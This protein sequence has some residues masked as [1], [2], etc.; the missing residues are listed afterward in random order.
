MCEGKLAS[1]GT[2]EER[3]NGSILVR[4]FTSLVT[5]ESTNQLIVLKISSPIHREWILLMVLIPG[6]IKSDC[7]IPPPNTSNSL[8][9]GNASC[10]LQSQLDIKLIKPFRLCFFTNYLVTSFLGRAHANMS[11]QSL[12]FAGKCYFV[13]QVRDFLKEKIHLKTK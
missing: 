6:V 13:K 10:L 7:I 12:T 8:V 3:E 5:L 4:L 2:C 9:C 11:S 1:V